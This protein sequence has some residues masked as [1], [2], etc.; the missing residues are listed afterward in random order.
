ML[1]LSGPFLYYEQLDRVI[2]E[3]VCQVLPQA[4]QDSKG[5][6]LHDPHPVRFLHFV[7]GISQNVFAPSILLLQE[8]SVLPFLL[9]GAVWGSQ[10]YF[11]HFQTGHFVVGEHLEMGQTGLVV[12]LHGD[13]SGVACNF[14][15]EGH[16]PPV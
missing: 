16:Q 14:H 11:H 4:V 10:V 8:D 6:M 3:P 1:L 12:Q 2:A 7:E 15:G 9:F 5:N 13:S